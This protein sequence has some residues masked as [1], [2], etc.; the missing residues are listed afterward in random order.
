MKPRPFVAGLALTLVLQTPAAAHAEDL[1]TLS[2]TVALVRAPSL[3]D[4]RLPLSF[5]EAPLA[6][7]FAPV[8]KDVRLSRGAIIAIVVVGVVVI[9]LGLFVAVGGPKHGGI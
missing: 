3:V 7:P 4:L 2:S 5:V 9:A 8:P 1:E 6:S